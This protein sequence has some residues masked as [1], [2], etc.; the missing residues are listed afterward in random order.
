[1]LFY[2][3]INVLTKNPTYLSD[4]NIPRES[5]DLDIEINRTILTELT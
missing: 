4:I 1:M 3:I 2:C 5:I